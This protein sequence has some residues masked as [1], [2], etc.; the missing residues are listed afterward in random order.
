MSVIVSSSFVVTR[1]SLHPSH[2]IIINLSSSFL[3]LF[4]STTLFVF[5]PLRIRPP[6]TSPSKKIKTLGGGRNRP[7]PLDLLNPVIG[8][9][10]RA[11]RR[12]DRA[13]PRP[14]SSVSAGSVRRGA[15]IA[16]SCGEEWGDGDGI[17][18]GR[19]RDDLR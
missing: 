9:P 18:C 4:Y 2:A 1:H 14:S 17:R 10:I 16:V 5:K 8:E 13:I 12:V 6:P 3:L 7:L 19:G 15:R 11:Y